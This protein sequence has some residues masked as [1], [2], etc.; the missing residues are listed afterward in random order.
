LWLVL[1]TINGIRIASLVEILLHVVFTSTVLILIAA[2]IAVY[3]RDRTKAQFIFSTAVII[4]LLLILALPSNP[5]N[6]I[7]LLAVGGAPLYHWAV[8][9]ASLAGCAIL[10]ILVRNVI[11]RVEY[12]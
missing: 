7:V 5:V 10:V 4:V 6:L 3:Y 2:T 8:I 9:A 1:L 12:S 11:R